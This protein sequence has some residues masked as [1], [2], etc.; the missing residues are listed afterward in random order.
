M[1]VEEGMA[2]NDIN[3]TGMTQQDKVG[4]KKNEVKKGVA[5]SPSKLPHFIFTATYYF[6]F[7][8]CFCF[9]FYRSI[10]I[11]LSVISFCTSFLSH[12]ILHPTSIINNFLCALTSSAANM[13]NINPAPCT[14]MIMFDPRTNFSWS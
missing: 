6:C 5:F 1:N 2:R 12:F 14:P 4:E 3:G 13:M 9:C 7:C 8:S 11:L 10:H